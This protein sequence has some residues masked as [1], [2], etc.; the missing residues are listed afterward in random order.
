[1][2]CLCVCDSSSDSIRFAIAWILKNIFFYFLNGLSLYIL[3]FGFFFFYFSMPSVHLLVW[4]GLFRFSLLYLIFP[5]LL[6]RLLRAK[7]FA[8]SRVLFRPKD[9]NMCMYSAIHLI[10]RK[11][12]TKVYI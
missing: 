8:C 2:L 3:N 6:L 12:Y 7:Y 9:L 1:M 5:R 10:W 11:V 4:F